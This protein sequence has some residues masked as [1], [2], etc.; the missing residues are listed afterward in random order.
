MPAAKK[1]VRRKPARLDRA[2]QKKREQ[3]IIADLKAGEMSYREI[4][5]KHG[6]SLPTVNAK[7]RKAGIRRPRGR[8]RA[9]VVAAAKAPRRRGR[10]AAA[11]A[12]AK[13]APR[14]RRRGRPRRVGRPGRP[15]ARRPGRPPKAAGFMDAFRK[16][17]LG[18]FPNLTLQRYDRLVR[19]IETETR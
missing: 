10:P 7:A 9:A 19:I 13:A 2:A 12:V 15:A 6:V 18:Y 4:A 8:R 1:V 11:P 14:K 16:M 17:V 3:L 5:H